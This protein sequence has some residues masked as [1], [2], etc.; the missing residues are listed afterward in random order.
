MQRECSKPAVKLE[1]NYCEGSAF[2][3]VAVPFWAGTPEIR[4]PVPCGKTAANACIRV[5]AGGHNNI[6][7]NPVFRGMV[8]RH[9]PVS[10]QQKETCAQYW[11]QRIVRRRR[12]FRT[13]NQAVE[14]Q[15]EAIHLRSA[16]RDSHY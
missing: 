15:D 12:P 5:G 7:T 3:Y 6:E 16:Q 2:C 11:H 13:P 9:A 10:F 4:R 8:R 14:S 1:N